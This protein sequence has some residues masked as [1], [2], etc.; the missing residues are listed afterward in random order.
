[1]WSL[2]AS[3]LSPEASDA[4]IAKTSQAIYVRNRRVIGAD[5]NLILP[6]TTLSLHHIKQDIQEES[7]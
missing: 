1:L 6:G 2:A 3:T 7:P 4:D 5:P